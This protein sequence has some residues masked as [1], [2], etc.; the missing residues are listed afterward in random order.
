MTRDVEEMYCITVKRSEVKGMTFPEI[1]RYWMG[2]RVEDVNEY[3]IICT[4]YDLETDELYIEAE[5]SWYGDV[6]S[7]G[8]PSEEYWRRDEDGFFI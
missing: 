7:I 3:D 1:F 6:D 4:G 8:E 5:V 2:N